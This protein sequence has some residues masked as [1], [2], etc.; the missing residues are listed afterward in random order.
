[1]PSATRGG[2]GPATRQFTPKTS[3]IPF[4]GELLFSVGL[5]A[6]ESLL[7]VAVRWK[8]GGR[9][10]EWL[11]KVLW[12]LVERALPDERAAKGK[13]REAV[14]VGGEKRGG[15]QVCKPSRERG[16]GRVNEITSEKKEKKT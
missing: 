1:L 4:K 3:G 13:S 6:G 5:T 9:D 16:S 14:E 8:L 15:A 7:A 10:Q 11:G 12:N 2:G